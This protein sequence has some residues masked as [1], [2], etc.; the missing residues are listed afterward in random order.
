[1]ALFAAVSV[2][3]LSNVIPLPLILEED[4]S[5]KLD[6]SLVFFKIFLPPPGAFNI[7]EPVDFL[8]VLPLPLLPVTN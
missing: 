2:L 7:V 6:D 5:R 4:A 8:G 3:I 1:M